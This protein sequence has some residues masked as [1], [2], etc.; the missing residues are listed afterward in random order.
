MGDLWLVLLG[1]DQREGAQA[2]G[3]AACT[4]N[5]PEFELPTIA[6]ADD[7]R[8]GGRCRSRTGQYQHR[9]IVVGKWAGLCWCRRAREDLRDF[10]G[11]CDDPSPLDVEDGSRRVDDRLTVRRDSD[12]G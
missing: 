7:C 9:L 12:W 6:E 4:I 11:R 5:S 1:R 10:G 8:G 2:L 3:V